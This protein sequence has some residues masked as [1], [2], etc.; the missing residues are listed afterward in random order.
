MKHIKLLENFNSSKLFE[1]YS[2]GSLNRLPDRTEN[3]KFVEFFDIYNSLKMSDVDIKKLIKLDK[4]FDEVRKLRKSSYMK[5]ILNLDEEKEKFLKSLKEGKRYNPVFKHH[6]QPYDKNK[7]VERAKKLIKEFQN[8]NCFLSRYYINKLEFLVSFG[9]IKKLNKNSKEYGSRM[10]NLYGGK[11]DPYLVSEAERIIANNP[12]VKTKGSKNTVTPHQLAKLARK[13]L[14]RLGY[15]KWKVYVVPNIIPRM[16]VRDEYRVE[17]NSGA[18]F[19]R[20]DIPGLLAHEIDGHVGRRFHGDATGL[21]LFRTGLTGKNQ[22]DE[23]LAIFNSLKVKKPKANV[24]FNI[25]FFVVLANRCHELDFYDLFMFGRN[26]VKDNDD[27]LFSKVMRIKRICEDTSLLTGDLEE[28]EYL[29]GYLLVAKLDD[30][31]RD[32]I[33][34]YNVGPDNFNDLDRIKAFLNLNKF[35]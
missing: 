22:L 3:Q 30:S 20:N 7:M 21:N 29:S 32:E 24:L 5:E 15:D 13:E 35:K 10:L 8:F 18:M 27:K 12:Y 4:E 31:Q 16:C 11:I 19:S 6:P 9:E 25:S 23:G 26:Y 17:I 34:K 33:L 14:K 28:Q 1:E 2:R